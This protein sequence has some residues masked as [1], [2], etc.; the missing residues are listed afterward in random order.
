[1]ITNEKDYNN[2]LDQLQAALKKSI[3]AATNALGEARLL[4]QG[5]YDANPMQSE[6]DYLDLCEFMEEL[7]KHN[8]EAQNLIER[9]YK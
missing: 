8:D 7:D 1:M 5:G 9:F 4:R 3:A 2:T 6:A